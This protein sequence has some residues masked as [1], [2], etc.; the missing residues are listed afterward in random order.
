LISAAPELSPS[1]V[2][3][4]VT[5]DMLQ[6]GLPIWTTKAILGRKSGP[7]REQIKRLF[8]LSARRYGILLQAAVH[9]NP[10]DPRKT[11]Q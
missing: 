4:T 3:D 1:V 8:M 5:K 6:A 10:D 7:P 9:V 11:I 2:Q